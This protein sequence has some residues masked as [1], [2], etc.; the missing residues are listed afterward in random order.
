MDQDYPGRIWCNME[1]ITE[2]FIITEMRERESEIR[3]FIKYIVYY[4]LLPGEGKSLPV[5]LS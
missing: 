2:T 5:E 3:V 1:A 4:A